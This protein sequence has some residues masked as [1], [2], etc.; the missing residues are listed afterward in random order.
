MNTQPNTRHPLLA[1]VLGCALLLAAMQGALAQ[2]SHYPER[3]TVTREAAAK[4]HGE[5][6]A[7]EKRGNDKAAYAA[8][9]ESADDG[10][11]P[12]MRKLGEIYDAGNDAV[13]RDF[14]ESI[15]WYQRARE[16]GEQIPPPKPRPLGTP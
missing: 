2:Y 11:A 8:F 16:G 6:L 5:G 10:Y 1:A 14:Y 4:R 15:R 7:L 13:E 9:R 3:L 12:S